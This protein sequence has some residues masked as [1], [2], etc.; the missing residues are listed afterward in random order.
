MQCNVNREQ[1]QHKPADCTLNGTKTNLEPTDFK[2]DLCNTA[3]LLLLSNSHSA[4]WESA[5]PITHSLQQLRRCVI[6]LS[7][8]SVWMLICVCVHTICMKEI[9]LPTKGRDGH[10]ITQKAGCHQARNTFNPHPSLIVRSALNLCQWW[11]VGGSFRLCFPTWYVLD[12][13][14]V[15]W[16]SHK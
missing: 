8:A 12:L 5:C 14:S 16:L 11:I 1:Q 4:L 6:Y 15:Y 2:G 3:F 10:D 13:L 7:N 9:F